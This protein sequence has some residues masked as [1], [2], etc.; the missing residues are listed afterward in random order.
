M[1]ASLR[2]LD[3][4]QNQFHQ[5]YAP[6]Q[7][8][9]IPGQLIETAWQ[10]H[11][12]HAELDPMLTRIFGIITPA[13]A[14]MRHAMLRPEMRVGRPFTPSHSRMY[15]MIR[16]TF[17]NGAEILSL[18]VPELLLGD[19]KSP[20]PFAPAL[21]PLG[22]ILVNSAPAEARAD[23]IVYVVGKRLAEQRAELLPRAFFPSVPELTALLAAAVRVSR[24]EGAKDTAGAALDASL[25]DVLTPDERNHLRAVITQALMEGSLLDVKRWSQLADLSSMR[26]GLLLCGDVDQARRA[27][28]AEP[29]S[30]SDLTPREKL[31]ELYKFAT[32]DLYSDLRGAIGIAVG[33]G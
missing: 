30:P 29:Q 7:L 3:E 33:A 13:V 4:E 5:D 27:I 8:S 2:P 9:E 26:A 23:N 31:G 21:A 15:E 16:G 18:P 32:S 20:I 6:V 10:S 12:F 25:S 22:A 1:L 19:G 28:N 11:V 17:T 24:S 14:R